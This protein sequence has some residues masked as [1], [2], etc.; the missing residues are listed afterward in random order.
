[1]MNFYRR[2]FLVITGTLCPLTVALSGNPK[3]LPWKPDMKTAFTAAKAALV[4]GVPL[5]HPLP[6]AVLALVMDA[7]D[8]HVGAVL[9]QQVAQHWQLLGFFSKKCNRRVPFRLDL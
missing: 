8:A 3:A 7:S 6:G 4:A 2:F 1:M 5:A 9:Q